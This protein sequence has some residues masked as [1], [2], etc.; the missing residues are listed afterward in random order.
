[1]WV[2]EGVIENQ[3][4]TEQAPLLPLGPSPTY[5]VTEQLSALP[6]RGEYLRLCPFM[7]QAHQVEKIKIKN[8]KM[9]YMKEQIK[10]PEKIQLSNK[11]IANLSDA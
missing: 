2:A 7:K 1:M 9:V 8:K 11:D 3:W 5:S 10:A 6:H 4:R